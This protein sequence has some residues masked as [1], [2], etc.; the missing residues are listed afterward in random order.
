MATK[1]TCSEICVYIY[2]H[3]VY[4]CVHNLWTSREWEPEKKAVTQGV[5]HCHKH[6]LYLAAQ[7]EEVVE[8]VGAE[9]CCA[10]LG[11]VQRR[12]VQLGFEGV[13][14]RVLQGHVD[15]VEQLCRLVHLG[16]GLN[17]RHHVAVGGSSTGV[18]SSGAADLLQSSP[19]LWPR[20]GR[21]QCAQ[22]MK[23]RSLER[24]WEDGGCAPTG[25]DCCVTGKRRS[26]RSLKPH[27]RRV[28]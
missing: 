5:D 16:T 14:L 12:S 9:V 21:A 18:R 19:V 27:M 20:Q 22:G 10:A 2:T 8:I 23:R 25:T 6:A 15:P 17:G 26:D 7:M 13:A 3:T 1:I 28:Y 4:V 24:R 11:D